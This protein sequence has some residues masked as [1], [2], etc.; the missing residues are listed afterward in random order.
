MEP[1]GRSRG[2]TGEL[3]AAAAVAAT[4]RKSYCNRPN[5][6]QFPPFGSTSDTPPLSPLPPQQAL[7]RRAPNAETEIWR[8]RAA[9][10][11]GQIL[12]VRS[13]ELTPRE[14]NGPAR[15]CANLFQLGGLETWGR[16]SRYVTT[17]LDQRRRRRRRRRRVW[18]LVARARSRYV[19]AAR[20]R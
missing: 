6:R 5:D 2:S 3:A 4:A 17:N 19:C 14:P 8:V 20:L 7:V 1:C 12:D 13:S 11:A 18:R 15:K 9:F 10:R 16:E